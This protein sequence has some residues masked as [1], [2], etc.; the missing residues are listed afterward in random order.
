[1]EKREIKAQAINQNDFP[2][3]E[4]IQ[5]IKANRGNPIS[6]ARSHDFNLSTTKILGVVLL[7]PYFSSITN[8]ECSSK[9]TPARS[10]RN[11]KIPK[12]N[13]ADHTGLAVMV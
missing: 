8:M 13:N 3:R 11:P 7:N 6:R 5:T 1:M 4:Y 10:E 12:N 9:G 2:V